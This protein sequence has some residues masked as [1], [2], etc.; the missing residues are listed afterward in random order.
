MTFLDPASYDSKKRH[1]SMIFNILLLV[2]A[3]CLDT[4][5]ASAAYGTNQ[6]RFS[7]KQI[8]AANGI[9]SGCL[10]ISLLFGS[11]IRSLVPETLTREIGFICLLLLGMWKLAD[12]AVRICL[13]RHR[14]VN[15]KIRFRFSE[16]CFIINIYADP[17]RADADQNQELSWKEVIFFSLAMS[18]DSLVAG[19]MAAFL[20]ISVPL[21]VLISFLM[22]E[23]F[24]YAG[25]WLGRKISGRCPKDLSWAGGV[26]FLILA[27]LKR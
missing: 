24:T 4:F 25:L 9:C 7:A 10:G 6:V 23:L 16:L 12:S 27:F 15:K 2:S 1:N 21:T 17:L 22:G 18:I 5:V 13:K 3:I 14:N 26:L 19:T 11:L 20:Q 8:A